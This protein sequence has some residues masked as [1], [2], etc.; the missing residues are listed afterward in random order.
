MIKGGCLSLLQQVEYFTITA[1][2]DLPK[3]IKDKKKLRKHLSESI[4]LLFIGSNDY[5]PPMNQNITDKFSP[6]DFADFLI[7]ELT[8]HIKVHLYLLYFHYFL[9]A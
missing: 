2:K 6:E 9:E 1:T 7:D 4:Y 8:K 3:A 5:F